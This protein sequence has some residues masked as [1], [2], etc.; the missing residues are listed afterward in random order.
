MRP[1]GGDVRQV[2]HGP[3][4]AAYPDW[5]PDGRWIAFERFVDAETSQV[6][7]MRSDGTHLRRLTSRGSNGD[8]A[9]SP[10]GRRIVFWHARPGRA[11]NLYTMK[12]DGS[13]WRRV[14]RTPDVFE[15]FPQYS[16]DGRW[17]AYT[18]YRAASPAVFVIRADGS[19]GHQI[20]ATRLH[21]GDSDWS[22]DGRRLVFVSNIDVPHSRLFTIRPDGSG[23]R[24]LTRGPRRVD[25]FDPSYS[26]DG[27]QIVFT[28][29]RLA[30]NRFELWAIDADGSRIRR[31]TRNDAFEFSPDWGSRR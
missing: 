20:T 24:G 2:T 22:P 28:S 11:A 27:R 13:D 6:F 25:D 4:G 9:F 3:S 21:A 8:P 31:V 29:D 15:T 10:D 1:D 7:L 18:A 30:E 17:I 12:P 23:L 19:R 14:T 16:P 5:S 26:P